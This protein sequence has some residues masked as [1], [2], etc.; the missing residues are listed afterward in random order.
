[1][2]R[3]E[4]ST[5]FLGMRCCPFDAPRGQGKQEFM[6]TPV[7]NLAFTMTRLFRVIDFRL[8]NLGLLAVLMLVAWSGARRYNRSLSQ[9]RNSQD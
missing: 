3:E 1:M 2:V 4:E 8:V 9:S 7:A 5:A 6:Y